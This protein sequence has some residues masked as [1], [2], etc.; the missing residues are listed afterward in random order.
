MDGGSYG[1]AFANM[2]IALIVFGVVLGMAIVGFGFGGWW[3]VS[4]LHWQ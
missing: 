2:G 1:R 4:H 3:V